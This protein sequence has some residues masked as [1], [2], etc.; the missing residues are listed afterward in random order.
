MFGQPKAPSF[1]KFTV[2][3]DCIELNSYTADANGNASLLNTMKVVRT[4]EHTVPFLGIGN[5]NAEMVEGEK[6]VHNGQLYILKNGQIYNV[7]GHKVEQ[8]EQ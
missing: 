3:N 2:K 1:T 4:K 5:V 8:L 6:F 7:L